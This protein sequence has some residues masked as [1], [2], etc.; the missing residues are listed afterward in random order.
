MDVPRARYSPN[1]RDADGRLSRS[2][3]GTEEPFSASKLRDLYGDTATFRQRFEARLAELTA[4]GWLLAEDTH[5]MRDD[6][7]MVQAD[8]P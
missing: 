3:V 5:Y 6:V 4:E 7:A 8:L 1:V 2:T